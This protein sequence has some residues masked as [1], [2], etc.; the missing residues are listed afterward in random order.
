MFMAIDYASPSALQ[1]SRDRNELDLRSAGDRPLRLVADVAPASVLPFRMALSALGELIHSDDR[2]LDAASYSQVLDPV[3]TVHDD[4]VFFEAFSRDQSAYGVVIV[5]RTVLETRGE[6]RPGTTNIDF[7]AWLWGALGEMRSS[8]RTCLRLDPGGLE[9]QTEKRGGRFEPKADLPEAWVR[10]F[11]Q[12]QAAA[13]MPGTRLTLAPVDLLS[14]IRFL[15]YTKAK[16]SPRALRYELPPGEDAR[17]IIEPFEHEVPL[18]GARHGRTELRVIRTWGRRRLRLLEPLLP[19]ASAARVYLKGRALP[20]FYVVDL[21]GVSFVLGLTGWTTQSFTRSA[22]QELSAGLGE[23]DP[24]LSEQALAALSARQVIRSS[25]LAAQLGAPVAAV[26]LALSRLCRRG[27]AT[28]DI[29]ARAFRHRELFATPIDASLEAELFPPD[30]RSAAAARLL[31]G[32]LVRVDGCSVEETTSLRSFKT[33]E[34]KIHR[35]VVHRD[36]R[37]RGSMPG[38]QRTEIV[39]SEAGR[40]IFG[41]CS[42]AFFAENLLNRGPCAHMVALLDASAPERP[43]APSSRAASV[44]EG[45]GPSQWHRSTEEDE[46]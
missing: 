6:V 14:A 17:L 45:G 11:L 8:R 15:R 41:T 10:G 23:A 16:I 2:W 32:G 22:G 28:Y 7:T 26:E 31:A 44:P 30:E 20:S 33:P 19:Y 9:L 35:E 13:V 1:S 24:I 3:V 27:R 43:D 38:A 29:E 4:R 25:E 46:E 36:Y 40:V 34:G 18:R 42:C 39:V 21:P 12:M 5:D 37:V